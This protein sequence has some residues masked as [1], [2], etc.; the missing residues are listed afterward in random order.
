[1]WLGSLLLVVS[2]VAA[3]G[4]REASYLPGIQAR[5]NASDLVCIGDANSPVRTGVVHLID[6]ANRDQLS[7]DVVLET[8]LKGQVPNS[9]EIRVLGDYVAAVTENARGFA[10]SGPPLGFVH[11]GQNLL[12]LRKGPAQDEFAVTVPIYQT[13]IPLADV[14]PDYP[15]ATSPGFV[16]AVITTELEHAML[17]SED[18]VRG[19]VNQGFGDPLLSDIGYIN[20]VLGYLGLSDGAAE[21][22]RFSGSAPVA[23]QRD[24]AVMLFFRDHTE[25]EPTVISLLLDE[26]ASAWKRANAARALGRHGDSAALEPL[27]S[28]VSQ[29]AG[30]ERLKS[31]HDD[32]ESSLE[33][34]RHRL[35][36]SN[37]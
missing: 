13:A 27:E 2:T 20:Y 1:M 14:R 34:L 30:T 9:S 31:L 3:S 23:I 12:F 19:T 33:S 4:A 29:P 16:K 15:T 17:Q 25:Y 11:K 32:A 37:R 5:W 26:S 8:C 28:V 18:S 35:A 10:Y 7:A 21:L 36:S 24:I 6:G 22:S